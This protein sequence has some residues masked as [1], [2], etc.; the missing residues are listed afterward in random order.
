MLSVVH[1]MLSSLRRRRRDFAVLAALG[2]DRGWIRRAIHWQATAFIVLPVV[3]GIPVGLVVGRLV[4]FA[5]ADSMGAVNGAST[6]TILLAGMAMGLLVLANAAALPSWPVQF[7]A[8]SGGLASGMSVT[9]PRRAR[10][11]P[12][13]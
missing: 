7:G 2:A 12:H 3:V 10:P 1:V 13:G 9:R 5:F 4:F 8:A 11:L 6:P